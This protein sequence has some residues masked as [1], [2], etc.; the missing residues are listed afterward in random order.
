VTALRAELARLTCLGR[1][2]G[3]AQEWAATNPVAA[4]P[5]APTTLSDPL[6]TPLLHPLLAPSTATVGAAQPGTA[7]LQQ[8]EV[9]G[10]CGEAA[11]VAGH[12]I[13][14][15]RWRGCGWSAPHQ[16]RGGPPGG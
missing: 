2:G 4:L 3:D 9:A 13:G 1:C 7:P 6:L 10:V 14:V 12:W 8:V 15:G 16:L 5:C 11:A